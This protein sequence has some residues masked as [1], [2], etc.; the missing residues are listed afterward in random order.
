MVFEENFSTFSKKN[1]Y[2][3]N[4]NFLFLFFGQKS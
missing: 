4:V 3:K 2:F 1:E